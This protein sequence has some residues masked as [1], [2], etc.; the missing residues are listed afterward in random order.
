MI[1][2]VFCGKSIGKIGPAC[3]SKFNILILLIKLCSRN[4]RLAGG[5]GKIIRS[6]YFITEF[7][8]LVI[9]FDQA[10][11]HNA[12]ANHN[13][14]QLCRIAHYAIKTAVLRG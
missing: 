10:K 13:P 1:E 2:I 4:L 12:A 6:R 9:S 11:L 8:Y 5:R 7:P 3:Q 14:N